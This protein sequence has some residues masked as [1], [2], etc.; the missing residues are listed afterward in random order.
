MFALYAG[1]L[2]RIVD[3]TVPNYVVCEDHDEPGETFMLAR[4]AYAG[5]VSDRAATLARLMTSE[6]RTVLFTVIHDHDS[7]RWALRIR[8][9]RRNHYRTIAVASK[10]FETNTLVQAL[11]AA[12]Y[13]G[14][15]VDMTLSLAGITFAQVWSGARHL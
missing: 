1:T 14:A 11:L 7:N 8:N 13:L 9:P 15:K 12:Q 4:S 5:I 10:P 3:N 6:K 2:Y